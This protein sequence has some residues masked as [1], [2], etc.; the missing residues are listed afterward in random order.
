[1]ADRII[2]PRATDDNGD[3]VSGAKATFF[4]KGT[5]TPLTVY[6]DEAATTPVAVPL[7]ADAEG[8]FIP[9]YTTSSVKVIVTDTE[10]VNLP[11]YPSDPHYVSPASATGAS[12]VTFS[13]ITGNAATNVQNAVA[14]LTGLWNA[15]TAYGRSLIA[16]ADAAAARGVLGLTLLDEDDFASDSDTAVATQQSIKAYVDSA[17]PFTE[18]YQSTA[19]TMV[20]AGLLTL[21]HGLSSQPKMIR[22]Y[23][24]CTTAE[25]GYVVGDNFDIS[26]VMARGTTGADDR[27]FSVRF[28]DTNILVRNGNSAN[29]ANS[30]A[31][32][33]GN[34]APL[35]RANWEL[36][37][38]AWA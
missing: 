12:S 2:L 4:Q 21:A 32:N 23:A 27:T 16:A 19:Q 24:K 8:V 31:A 38:E 13:P 18:E 36:Y 14:N 33:S 10:D 20:T 30:I 9:V 22:L 7:E 5:T 1:M 25:E 34:A 11:G 3:I 35:S 26:A 15:V 37:V 29:F 6:S 17:T 28:D